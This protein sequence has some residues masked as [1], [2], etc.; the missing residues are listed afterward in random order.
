MS[1]LTM[2]AIA[3]LLLAFVSCKK[4]N[5]AQEEKRLTSPANAIFTTYPYWDVHRAS[6]SPDIFYQYS[7]NGTTWLG[8]IKITTPVPHTTET[9]TT[10][11]F[12]FDKLFVASK[13]NNTNTVY[14]S[15]TSN[16]SSWTTIATP[17]QSN[18][19]PAIVDEGFGFGPLAIYGNSGGNLVVTRSSD[20]I[21]W[22]SP[23]TIAVPGLGAGQLAGGLTGTYWDK[24]GF[25]TLLFT[26]T[27]GYIGR[28]FIGGTVSYEQLPQQAEYEPDIITSGGF[29]FK[30]RTN[31]NVFYVKPDGGGVVQIPG[32]QAYAGP[33]I[34]SGGSRLVVKI[35]GGSNDIYHAISDDGGTTWTLARS[36]GKTN[37]SPDVAHTSH[38]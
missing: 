14:L 35:R 4:A 5:E 24:I 22:S 11:V 7:T 12:S 9:G 31:R 2:T 21:T 38:N 37:S 16:G 15:Y 36:I 1:K 34:T 26:Q 30:S 20:G 28:I 33:S 25:T 13:N 27:N 10:T 17:L 32:A 3:V 19:T 8:E 6:S 29:V 23:V 18:H